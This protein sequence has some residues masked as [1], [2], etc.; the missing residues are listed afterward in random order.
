MDSTFWSVEV[1]QAWDSVPQ[2]EEARSLPLPSFSEDSGPWPLPFYPVL[3]KFPSDDGGEDGGDNGGDYQEQPLLLWN[4]D[5]EGIYPR[6]D[7]CG[8]QNTWESSVRDSIN[9]L[10]EEPREETP[11]PGTPEDAAE[12]PFTVAVQHWSCSGAPHRGDDALDAETGAG[13]PS[14]ECQPLATAD[15]RSRLL[16]WLVRFLRRG[17]ASLLCSFRLPAFGS[18]EP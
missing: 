10:L 1:K 9:T 5:I 11:T 4:D 2:T 12:E 8:I 15:W 16:T 13:S 14:N 3:G 6:T 17:L 7:S 18:W